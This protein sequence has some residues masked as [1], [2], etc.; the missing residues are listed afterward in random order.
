MI[1]ASF[2]SIW[3]QKAIPVALRDGPGG[4]PLLVRL[5]YAPSNG[6]WLRDDRRAKPKW[7]RADTAWSIPKA[8]F[9]D[10]VRRCL[11]KYRA[12]Y[13]IQPYREMENCAP[14]CVNAVGV[15][16]TCSCRG[17]NHGSGDSLDK[18]YIVSETCA[19]RYGP[20]QYGARLL[21]PYLRARR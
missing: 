9:D 21:T 20:K 15:E 18:W 2:A 10:T 12:V 13:V 8:W 17:E 19:V 11:E 5:P 6:E 3:N 7:F 16:C 1:Q 14:A 4:R